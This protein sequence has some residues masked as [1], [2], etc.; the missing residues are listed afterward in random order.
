MDLGIRGDEEERGP[1][2]ETR[3]RCAREIELE[4]LAR[5]LSPDAASA[6]QLFRAAGKQWLQGFNGPYAIDLVAVDTVARWHRVQVTPRIA[7]FLRVAE[8]EALEIFEERRQER[9]ETAD[10]ER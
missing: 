3:S 5:V 8:D 1:C 10:Q 2:R 7:A 6:L 9:E 4:G